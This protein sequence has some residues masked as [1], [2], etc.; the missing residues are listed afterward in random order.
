MLRES[1]ILLR[2]F[3]ELE[4][5]DGHIEVSLTM[6]TISEKYTK[7]G[8][9]ICIED[10][11]DF[12]SV[13]MNTRLRA[14]KN[15]PQYLT[16]DWNTYYFMEEENFHLLTGVAK[17]VKENEQISGDNY[18]FYEA[19]N[20]RMAAILSDG[21]GSGEKACGDSE[22]VIE[23]ME[24]LLEAGFRKETA[25]QMING[26]LVAAGQEENLSTL[27]ICDINLYTGA[28]EFMKVGAACSYIKRG[29]LVDRLSALN[30][31]L[32]VFGQ[33]E[34]ES[35]HRV[36]QSGDYVIMLSDGI[37]DALSQGIGEE[38]LPE[39]IGRIEYTNPNEIANQILAYCLKQSGGQVRDDMT[40]LVIGVWEKDR[41]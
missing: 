27:D 34:T 10:V 14:A 28:C 7:F 23:K 29:R 37:L 17:A 11:A 36:L 31:P 35:L 41:A 5:E 30:F 18:S 25:V 3:F 24:R 38:V 22:R 1:G 33:I 20:G 21:M 15:V 12:L 13:A 9:H 26:A 40:V 6:K 39:I 32:G 4:R 16:P 2:N 8:E 19:E